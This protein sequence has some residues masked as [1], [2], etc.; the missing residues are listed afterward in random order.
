M[1]TLSRP[2]FPS[3]PR[4]VP[5]TTPG[6]SAG[7]TSAAQERTIILRCVEQPADIEAHR[8]GG[9]QAEIRQHRIAAAD[10]RNAKRDVAEPIALGDRLQL[11]SGIGD[12]DEPR[13]R[14]VGAD[15]SLHALEEILLQDIRFER[16]AGLARYDEERSGRVDL[17]FDRSDLR[18]VGR[19]EHQ[20]LGMAVLTSERLG[21]HLRPEARSAHAE[22]KDVGEVL[23]PDILGQARRAQPIRLRCCLDDVEPA[24]PFR[25]VGAGPQ[26]RVAGPEP[27]HVAVMPPRLRA[28]RR[29][30]FRA[31]R[32]A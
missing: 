14:L 4:T 12:G 16:A 31:R 11:R 10:A 17:A 27:A 6:L 30:P 24:E 23:L 15:R 7:G 21:K 5:S 2:A 26:A 9:H 25:L 13:S 28:R 32:E 22:E 29:P 3:T 8:G 20:Q 19:V 1:V 18:R